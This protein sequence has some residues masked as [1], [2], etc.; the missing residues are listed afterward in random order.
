[1]TEICGNCGH[2][3]IIYHQGSSCSQWSIDHNSVSKDGIIYCP[4]K[5]F[6]PN[7]SPRIRDKIKV[8]PYSV[9]LSQ[10][11]VEG[12]STLSDKIGVTRGLGYKAK[13]LLVK[14][15]KEFIKELK[16]ELEKD[17]DKC[18]WVDC[19]G[20]GHKEFETI[21]KLAGKELT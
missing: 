20:G 16:E 15:V 5:E 19:D 13:V 7:H 2:D 10:N 9:P 14:N 12:T 8:A 17:W 3:N 1:M 4:C 11:G 21:N 6:K 18:D